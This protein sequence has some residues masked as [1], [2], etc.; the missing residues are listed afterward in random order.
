MS[1]E[2]DDSLFLQLPLSSPG[3][4][5]A[6]TLPESVCMSKKDHGAGGPAPE[7]LAELEE[8]LGYVFTD[9]ALLFRCLT[10][11]SASKTRLESNERLEFLG[12]AVLGLTICESLFSSFPKNNE[13]ELT[14]IK[15]VVVSRASCAQLAKR[16]DLEKYLIL[17]RGILAHDRLPSSVLAAGIEALIGGIYVDGGFEKAREVVQR[18]FEDEIQA[19]AQLESGVN[20][21]SLLQQSVQ[22]QF[23][24]TPGYRVVEEKGPD[25]SKCF[26]VSA[27]VGSQ[28]FPAAWGPSKKSAEQRAAE[29]ALATMEGNEPPHAGE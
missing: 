15:S 27:L 13:G 6:D 18:L 28:V 19:A 5:T 20:Y 11:A 22:K 2:A 14:R 4:R 23:G 7:L 21:K 3:V 25:H 9:R 29:N 1:A 12:D 10:H 16:I 17:G 24:A 26:R 8:I